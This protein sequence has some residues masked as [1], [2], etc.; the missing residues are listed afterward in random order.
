MI[1]CSK[2]PYDHTSDLM[3]NL[4]YSAASGAVHLMGNLAP[5]NRGNQVEQIEENALT[6]SL[7]HISEPTR[8]YEISYAVFCL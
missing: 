7:I 2:M 8:R 5:A 6:L 4:P 3:V 1:S